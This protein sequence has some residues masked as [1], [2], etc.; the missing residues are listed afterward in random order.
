VA[1][2]IRRSIWSR[3]RSSSGSMHRTT[4]PRSAFERQARRQPSLWADGAATPNLLAGLDVLDLEIA[5]VGDDRDS[6]HAEN[7]LRRLRRPGQT[8]AFIL[9]HDIVRRRNEWHIGAPLFQDAPL[10]PDEPDDEAETPGPQSPLPRLKSAFGLLSQCDPPVAPG[11]GGGHNCG[12][13]SHQR[14]DRRGTPAQADRPARLA[15]LQWHEAARP[16]RASIEPCFSRLVAHACRRGCLPHGRCQLRPLV[17]RCRGV[18]SLSPGYYREAARR[19]HS[20]GRRVGIGPCR[21]GRV[22]AGIRSPGPDEFKP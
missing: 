21:V 8:M 13:P 6:L 4:G 22:P 16:R 15:A 19:R 20:S 14:R 9:P 2:S 7:I 10:A 12:G 11:P 17:W 3:G 18:L 1:S 5:M